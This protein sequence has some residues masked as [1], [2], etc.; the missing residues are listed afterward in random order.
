MDTQE[1]LS[2]EEKAQ[3]IADLYALQIEALANSPEFEAFKTAQATFE[4]SYEYAKYQIAR[5]VYESLEL[6]SIA[7]GYKKELSEAVLE[8]KKTVKAGK[9]QMQY[10][11][12]SE[13][14]V[15]DDNALIEL[16]VKYPEILQHRT[17]ERG[18]PS[19]RLM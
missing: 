11:R 17:V 13:K 8:L 15:W 19:T 7:A 10:V 6:H 18:N 14:V 12:G 16:A 9:H 5:D 4:N 3:T 2:K 1:T